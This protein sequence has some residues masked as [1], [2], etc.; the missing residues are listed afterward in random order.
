MFCTFE[1]CQSAPADPETPSDAGMRDS[2]FCETRKASR[3]M[4][5]VALVTGSRTVAAISRSH[6]VFPVDAGSRMSHAVRW[7]ISPSAT[8]PNVVLMRSFIEGLFVSPNNS[9]VAAPKAVSAVDSQ[10][11]M[12][13]AR[14]ALK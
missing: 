12:P 10:K 1:P 6:R 9:Q 7:N 4:K 8:P 14:P 3:D 5:R 13:L 2:G 11:V